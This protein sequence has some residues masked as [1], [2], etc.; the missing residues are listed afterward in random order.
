MAK[1]LL[2]HRATLCIA[3]IMAF[4]SALG[5]GAG[6]L[7]LGPMME[8]ILGTDGGAGL[9]AM[10]VQHNAAGGWQIPSWLVEWLPDD[11]YDGVQ[12][13]IFCI[14]GLTLLGASANFLHQYLSQTLAI[15][16]I[17][18]VRQRLFAHVLTLPLSQVV[19]RG[20]SEYVSRIIRDAAA[21][22]SGFI[23]LLGKSVAQLTKGLAA[24]GA[25]LIF[26]WQIVLAAIVVGPVLA[27]VIRKLAKRIRR[28]SRGSLNAQ[29][30][31]LQLAT[32]RV[33]GLRAIKT[34]GG[35]PAARQRFDGINADVIRHE[36]KMRTAKAM[37][38]PIVE[39]L[40]ILVLGG[41]ALLAAKKILD[42]SMPFDDFILSI[43]SL[44]VAGASLRPLTGIVN[45]L[46]AAAP[47]AQRILDV[48]SE[49]G[50]DAQ[51]QELPRHAQAIRFDGVSYTYPNADDPALHDITLDVEFGSH[52]AIVG[53]NGSGKTTLLALLPRL[54]K[55]DQGAVCIDGVNIADA[56]LNSLRAQIGVVTQDAF[57]VQGTILDNLTLGR[58]D[59]SRAQA[60]EAAKAAHADGFIESMP[61]NWDAPV[62]EQGAS[63]SGGQRQR[64]SIARALLREPAILIL[65]EA[66]SQVDSESEAAIASAIRA[67]KGRT[68][69]VIA[70]RL[71]T[72][73]DC[74]RIVVMD[75]GRIVDV[76]RHEE[77]LGR[78]PLYERL[79][80]TQLVSVES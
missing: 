47:P 26:D 73:L 45:E 38:S 14:W 23:S 4:V 12:L 33:Q 3:V 67:I 79:I 74:D 62:S 61:G 15:R 77:L 5:L 78:C 36:L 53:P 68:V 6:L 39:T 64:L 25:A 43:G 27:V 8:Q 54:L 71:A 51:G 72:V 20:P 70:H 19:Q 17:A 65:D 49:A 29:Q 75:Q 31:L 42:G 22:E 44:A 30:E 40:A 76:G 7:S 66:T 21:L 58:P 10:A 35:E 69:L 18:T 52:V 48:L 56:S 46:N 59:A 11:R 80:S 32:E 24:L 1:L 2:E 50:E 16:T 41:L 28:G 55:P 63:L 57:I 37:S 60:I 34:S 13:L 9:H